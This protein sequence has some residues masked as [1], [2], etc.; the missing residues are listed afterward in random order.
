MSVHVQ[1]ITNLV[2]ILQRDPDSNFPL[3]VLNL[4]KTLVQIL[5][6]NLQGDRKGILSAFR[7]VSVVSR[8]PERFRLFLPKDQNPKDIFWQ[9]DKF[10]PKLAFLGRNTLFF[11]LKLAYSA[12]I[13]FLAEKFSKSLFRI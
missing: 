10:L 2:A 7:P 13:G 11:C 9:K 6:I 12:K 5:Q 8:T 4:K 1:Y 3:A